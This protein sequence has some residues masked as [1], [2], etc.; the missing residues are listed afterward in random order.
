MKPPSFP[1]S[2]PARPMRFIKLCFLLTPCC[3][4]APETIPGWKL[5]WNDEFDGKSI[6]K[7]HVRLL[8]QSTDPDR[9]RHTPP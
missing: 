8:F 3:F 4:A 2:Y 1:I 7:N 6:G 9:T 5:L